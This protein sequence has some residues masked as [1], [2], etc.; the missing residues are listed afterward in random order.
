MSYSSGQYIRKCRQANLLPMS[1]RF[2][3]NDLIIFHKI[4]YNLIPVTLPDYLTFYNGN[5]RLRSSHLDHLS[6]EC[7]LL[8]RNSLSTLLE[9]SFFYRT[10]TVW[11]SLPLELREVNI[12][13]MF[14][15][16]LEKY[17]WKEVLESESSNWEELTE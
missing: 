11:N 1:S 13:T 14:R 6:L 15:T 8:P 3:L 4:V 2:N 12:T 9:K 7:S 16:N 10:H 5:S 17:L